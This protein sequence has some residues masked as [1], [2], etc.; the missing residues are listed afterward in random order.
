MKKLFFLLL[1]LFLLGKLVDG[2]AIKV[3]GI[4]ITLFDIEQAQRELGVSKPK[5]VQFLIRYSLEEYE[6]KRLN[7]EVTQEEIDNG[8]DRMLAQ[9]GIPSKEILFRTL[10]LQGISK[11]EFL[12]KIKK[13]IAHSKLYR[14]VASSKVAQP[15]LQELR[16]IYSQNMERWKVADR[17]YITLYMSRDIGVLKEKLSN[18]LRFSRGVQIE[19]RV[20]RWGDI[21]PELQDILS[22][23]H[24]GEFS[25][26][27]PFGGRYAFLY[28]SRKEGERV[29]EFDEVVD[30]IRNRELLLRQ[31]RA[32]D[33]YFEKKRATAVI[34]YLR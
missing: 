7:I 14:M 3:N 17:Y 34:E 32:V 6:I 27:F 24:E 20:L 10:S 23:L 4:P 26:I 15:S 13:E 18:P 25:K 12:E 8:I 28:L 30:E 29:L 11:D 33:S 5:A 16:D 21:S 22:N 31:K 2:I 1:P 9:S 19:N